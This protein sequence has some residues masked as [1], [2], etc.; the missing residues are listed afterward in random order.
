MNGYTTLNPDEVVL[1]KGR[2]KRENN[3]GI[4][5]TGVHYMEMS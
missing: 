2:G 3:G 1:R 5:Q 4:D